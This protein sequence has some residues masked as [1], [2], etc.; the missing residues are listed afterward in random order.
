MAMIPY[1][2]THNGWDVLTPAALLTKPPVG[3]L[4][5]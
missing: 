5:L 4:I 1:S 2:D 3:E